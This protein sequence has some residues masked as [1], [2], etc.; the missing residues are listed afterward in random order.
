ML[1]PRYL[2]GQERIDVRRGLA[3][4]LSTTLQVPRQ[5]CADV[6]L[7]HGQSG[8]QGKEHRRQ[9]SAPQRS[10]AIVILAAQGGT[11][12]LTLGSVVVQRDPRVVHEAGQ[13]VPV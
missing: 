4:V 8:K 5:P 7:A 6:N 11:A 1:L 10:R 13:A 2:P 12:G 9:P 3:A